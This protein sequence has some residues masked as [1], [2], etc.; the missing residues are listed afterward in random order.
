MFPFGFLAYWHFRKRWAGL[1]FG[2]SVSRGAEHMLWVCLA[3]MNGP[4][5]YDM[6]E[7]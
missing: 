3:Y 4:F 2:I 7:M 6:K 5:G 1:V